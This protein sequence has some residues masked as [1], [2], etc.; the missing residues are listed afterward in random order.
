MSDFIDND[1]FSR[2][3]LL[4]G[5]EG[6]Y[7]LQNARV[8]IFGIG[9][10]GSWCAES[11]IRTGLGHLTIVDGDL[12]CAS[13]INRQ[14]MATAHTVGEVKTDAMCRHLLEINPSAD[15][16][17]RHELYSAE[18]AANFNLS[19]YDVIIDC[20]DSLAD[21]ALLILNATSTKSK[22]LSSMGAA[23]KINPLNVEVA[24]FWKV[25]GCPLARA[26]RD[27]FK[28]SGRKP[29]RKFQCV[30]SPELLKN[31][32]PSTSEVGTS[33]KKE[34]RPN[35]SLMHIT[36]IFGLTLAGLAI[37]HLTGK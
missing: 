23:L 22:F 26:L 20:I 17:A 18:T 25:K 14:L 24:E 5:E 31:C 32:Y 28:K 34:K 4:L 19:D 1:I 11:L 16:I 30:Y 21:K 37:E 13:N 3:K 33:D 10:V 6:F 29:H 36:A 27:R 8:I 9:G 15:I 12:V 2:S 7:R 35:G